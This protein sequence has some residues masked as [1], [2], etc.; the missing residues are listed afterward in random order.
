MKRTELHGILKVAQPALAKKGFVPVFCCFRF[1]GKT[2]MAYD[3]LV[4]IELPCELPVDGAVR[5]D[6]LLGWLGSCKGQEVEATSENGQVTLKCGRSKLDIGLVDTEFNFTMPR[7]GK[8]GGMQLTDAVLNALRAVMLS[9]GQDTTHEWRCGVSLRVAGGEATMYTTNNLAASRATFA[10]GEAPDVK[11][12][13]PPRFCELLVDML[14]ADETTAVLSF[15]D[16]GVL[17]VWESGIKLFSKVAH[18]PQFKSYE[19]VFSDEVCESAKSASVATPPGLVDVLARAELVAAEADAPFASFEVADGVLT[20]QAN[21]SVG[22]LT[23]RI[24]LPDHGDVKVEASPRFIRPL[25]AASARV[26]FCE[27]FIALVGKKTL[28]LIDVAQEG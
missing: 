28:H 15:V 18:K 17:V 10:A 11:I 3:D 19:E 25:L 5:G 12:L 16:G 8:A 24:K 6:L 26:A 4:G 14:K 1:N 7:A 23:E 27:S 22:N 20:V 2:V 21:S 13:L 9:L